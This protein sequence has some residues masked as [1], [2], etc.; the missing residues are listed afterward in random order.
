MDTK[1]TVAWGIVFALLIFFV[2]GVLC[3]LHQFNRYIN[4]PTTP[5]ELIHRRLWIDFLKQEAQ[6]TELQKLNEL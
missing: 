6:S 3:S 2:V 4:R 5:Q 1:E